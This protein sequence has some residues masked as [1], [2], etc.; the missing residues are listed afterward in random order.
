[1]GENTTATERL[2]R[3]EIF[4]LLSSS[5][6]RYVIAHL[7]DHPEGVTLRELSRAIAARENDCSVDEVTKKQRKRVYV[8]LHQTHVPKLSNAGVID[9]VD[10]RIVPG[11]RAPDLAPYLTGPGAHR[12]WYLYYL[13]VVLVGGLA[14]ALVWLEAPVFA[15]VETITVAVVVLL[16]IAV[17]TGVYVWSSWNTGVISGLRRR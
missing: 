13:A 12:P 4:D 3:D 14:F 6:R 10:D 5:R 7:L 8:S 16:V 1:M 2:S 11:D 15:A 9:R 17:L